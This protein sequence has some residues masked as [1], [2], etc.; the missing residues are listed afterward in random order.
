MPLTLLALLFARRIGGSDAG[1]HSDRTTGIPFCG[2]VGM[3]LLTAAL[4]LALTSATPLSA[5]AQEN[6][7]S[8]G[9]SEAFERPEL[10]DA[11][12]YRTGSGR[13]GPAYWQQRADYEIDVRLDTTSHRIEGADTITYTNNSPDSHDY[14]WVQLDQN[15]FDPDSRGALANPPD[16]RWRG[17]FEE[18]GVTIEEVEFVNPSGR[19][20]EPSYLITDTRMRI[21]LEEPIPP[22][23]STVELDIAWSFT[24]PEH[25]AD[26]MGRYDS[27]A[28]WVYQLAQWYPRMFVY[29]DV[30]GWN[31]QPYLGQ[32]EFY[33]EFGDFQVEVTV[34]RDL[35]VVATG[36]LQNPREV[37]TQRQRSRLEKARTSAKTVTIRSRNGIGDPAT[38]PEGSGPLT[39]RFEAEDVRDFT[40]AASKAF[41]W[42]AAGWEDVL[43]MSA[44]PP[45]GLSQGGD[46][47]PGWEMSTQYVRHSISFYSEEFYPYPYPVAI[48][49]GG[50]V[51]G[52]EYPMISF[53]SIDY[54][55]TSLFGVTDHEF[56]HM[57][58]PMLVQSDER[59]YFWMDEG[60][61]TFMNYYSNKAYYGEDART[62]TLR[63]MQPDAIARRMQSQLGSQ[64]SATQSDHIVSQ[65]LGFVAYR[66]PGFGLVLLRELI[67]GEERFDS[68]LRTY[69]ERWKYRHPKPSDFFRT[70]EDVAG[71]ELGWFWSGWFYETDLLDQAVDSVVV[72]GNRSTVHLSNQRELV[73]PAP[74]QVTYEDGSSTTVTLPVDVWM[75]SD[76]H[77]WRAPEGRRIQSVTLDPNRMLPDVDRTNN[78]WTAR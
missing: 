42:D 65:A 27:R 76:Y 50:T 49:V 28:G 2:P 63:L 15:L 40:W 55:G 16:A 14:L 54:R 46:S 64:P 9:N 31:P 11:D 35:I 12:S 78:T 44:Y 41:I 77:T 60:L 29:D 56:G 70:I 20:L 51:G 61:D 17:A 10:P 25:G 38:R 47:Q 6:P 67:L 59:R 22:G 68:A 45:E 52:M 13:P 48:N 71:E 69:V 53:C 5:A 73:M 30:N 37:L 1:P 39:W 75:R 72:S 36:E 57:W 26:R 34:P 74:M 19:R 62:R 32:G 4:T 43:I 66:K 24:I 18:G 3:W 7:S 8:W 23:G 33:T 21:A 58:F